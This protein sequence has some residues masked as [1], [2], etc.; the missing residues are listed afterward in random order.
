MADGSFYEQM[1]KQYLEANGLVLI[2]QNYRTRRGEIDLIMRDKDTLVFIEVR[3]R[4]LKSRVT[5]EES[6]TMSKRKRILRCAQ[7][8][9]TAK[10]A[11]NKDCRF[12]FIGI[13]PNALSQQFEINW[14]RSAFEAG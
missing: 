7:K 12:D 5:P 2:E 4:N 3:Y 8:Y 1:A 10:S 9:L 13:Q 11:W 6:M 14:I